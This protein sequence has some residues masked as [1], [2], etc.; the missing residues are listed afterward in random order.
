MDAIQG[1]GLEQEQAAHPEQQE[2]RINV[3]GML[4]KPDELIPKPS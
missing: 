1:R 2:R 4:L 3:V